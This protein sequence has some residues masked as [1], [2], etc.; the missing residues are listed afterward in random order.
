MSA[1][2]IWVARWDEFQT[3][4]KKRG[5]PWA[6]PWVKLYTRILDEPAYLD[7]TPETR[8]LL[9]GLWALFGRSR[10]TVT[11]DTR[12]LT[13]QLHQR[14]TKAQLETLN[15]AGW[16][17]FCSGTVLEQKRNAFWNSSAL[18]VETEEEEEETPSVQ[19]TVKVDVDGRTDG[20]RKKTEAEM[21]D[22][23]RDEFG[24]PIG[25][26]RRPS[27]TALEIPADVLNRL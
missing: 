27:T 4:Q 23:G 5:K 22:E 19:P 14:V 15:H 7:L 26:E 11:K 17:T 25:F 8:S 3:F 18:E 10:G 24:V 21:A 20:N 16:I 13:Q 1:E 12:R 9:V 2:Y 6:P